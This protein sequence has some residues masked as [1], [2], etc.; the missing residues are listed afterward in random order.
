[1][2]I[3]CSSEIST[4]VS[5]I[6]FWITKPF[7]IYSF[8]KHFQYRIF[9]GIGQYFFS[10]A[11][12]LAYSQDQLKIGS[13]LKKLNGKIQNPLL[14]SILAVYHVYFFHPLNQAFVYEPRKLL[15][16]N[17]KKNGLECNLTKIFGFVHGNQ[18]SWVYM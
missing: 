2:I 11:R 4:R 3:S 16:R 8:I 6:V 9:R 14:L 12:T 10:D 13:K 7:L 18:W 1:M 5:L 17:K 15:K